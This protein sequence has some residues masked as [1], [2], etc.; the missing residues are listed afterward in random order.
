MGKALDSISSTEKKKQTK[1]S[2]SLLAH[3]LWED[4]TM[5]TSHLCLYWHPVFQK[6][7]DLLL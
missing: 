2:L 6:P 1:K 4:V 7:G 3:F 5:S